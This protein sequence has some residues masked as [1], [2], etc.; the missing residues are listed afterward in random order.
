MRRPALGGHNEVDVPAAA[1]EVLV[2][3][4][5]AAAVPVVSSHPSRPSRPPEE[6]ADSC[7]RNPQ[8][9]GP[10]TVTVSTVNLRLRKDVSDHVDEPLGKRS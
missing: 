6:L 7:S 10:T 3:G 1:A 5:T 9:D 4:V 8:N 2:T